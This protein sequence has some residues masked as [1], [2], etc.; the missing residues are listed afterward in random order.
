MSLET[1]DIFS[2]HVH[3][4]ESSIIHLITIKAKIVN[5]KPKAKEH[6][7]LIWLKRE[8]KFI[9]LGT[10]RQTCRSLAVK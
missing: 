5:G 4:Y 1:I 8:P 10:G 3:E 9:G 2:E 7:K 6:A